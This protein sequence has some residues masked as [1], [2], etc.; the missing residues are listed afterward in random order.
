MTVDVYACGLARP[1]VPTSQI[2][3]SAVTALH[4]HARLAPK[5]GVVD[6]RGGSS[7]PDANVALL[8]SSADALREPLQ[9]C[10]EAARSLPLG[11]GLRARLGE[12]GRAAER[13]MR[14]ATGA[15][16][17]RGAMRTL[18]LLSAGAAVT[19]GADSVASFA[20]LVARIPDPCAP[21]RPRCGA[22]GP[23]G[24]ARG[25][26]PHVIRVGLPA[27][28]ASRRRCETPDTA[29]LNAWIA[30]MANLDDTCVARRGG[31]GAQRLVHRRA[32][33]IV[34]AGGCGTAEGRRRLE[35]LC[36]EADDRGLSM[37]GSGDLLAATLFLD[38]LA[39]A[40]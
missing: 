2:A 8:A 15:D 38:L 10:A 3:E 40:A 11:P 13:R 5:P 14:E 18:G 34:R 23:I 36:Q 35:S 9:Q 33:D 37:G 21:A 17:H 26:F 24:E 12:I 1:P 32:T 27:L 39:Q 22:R 7:H 6:G 19:E 31:T 28:R 29:A 20:A 16:T 4:T 25:G 30:I